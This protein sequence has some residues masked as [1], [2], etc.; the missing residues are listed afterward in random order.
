MMARNPKKRR[1][2]REGRVWVLSVELRKSGRAEAVLRVLFVQTGPN[3]DGEIMDLYQSTLRPLL[4]SLPAEAAHNLA[5]LG[6]RTTPRFALKKAFGPVP[7]DPVRLFGLNFPNRVGLA[8]GMDKN[9]AALGAWEAM[10]FGFI[11]AGTITARSAGEPQAAL[12][13]L[14]RAGRI[15]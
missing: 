13:P 14:S 11:E 10:G 1:R 4:F 8:A 7:Q 5:L 6:L 2:Q 9:A 15:D 3:P 12:L